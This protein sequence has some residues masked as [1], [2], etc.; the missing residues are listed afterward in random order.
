MVIR[1]GLIKTMADGGGG[2]LSMANRP[3]STPAPAQQATPYQAIAPN[4]S[5]QLSGTGSGLD[6]LFGSTIDPTERQRVLEQLQKAGA[7]VSDVWM[8][9][10][11]YNPS[12]EFGSTFSPVI[13]NPQALQDLASQGWNIGV[14]QNQNGSRTAD[15]LN[16]G[17]VVSSGNWVGDNTVGGGWL[18]S[19]ADQVV[20]ASIAAM[21]GAGLLGGSGN[22]T[23]A[24][25]SVPSLAGGTGLGT[26][27]G[28]G[29]LA[30]PEIGAA[31]SIGSTGMATLADTL[32]TF[33]SLGTVEG[34][35]A[36]AV[37]EIGA[38]PYLGAGMGAGMATMADTLPDLSAGTGLE[39]LPTGV[40]DP[41]NVPS[42]GLPESTLGA[43]LVPSIASQTAAGTM[44]A[45]SGGLLDWM[46]ANPGLA[47][48]LVTGVGGLLGG[49]GGGSSGGSGGSGAPVTPNLWNVGKAQANPYTAPNQYVTPQVNMTG[50]QNSGAW[51]WMKG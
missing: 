10:P 35:G 36:L 15:I 23:L 27:E 5:T 11:E 45:A 29:S 25:D 16:N 21:T 13:A 14:Q 46:K 1:S 49:M 2:L 40:V 8:A 18:G 43:S 3:V 24:A 41:V 17:N 31:S 7:N 22:A 19:H 30:V 50:Q 6:F 42:I 37:P 28:V 38:I 44:P 12:D 4:G 33:A 26:A 20:S 34:V 39:P 47:K 9:N 32:P 48:T 51:R